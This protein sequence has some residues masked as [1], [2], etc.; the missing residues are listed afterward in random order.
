MTGSRKVEEMRTAANKI[1]KAP[2]ATMLQLPILCGADIELGNFILGLERAD[3]TAQIAAIA[4]LREIE[5]LPRLNET[6]RRGSQSIYGPS[7]NAL[8]HTRGLRSSFLFRNESS[9][10]DQGTGF[11][12]QDWGRKFLPANGGCAYIDLTTGVDLPEVISARI[13]AALAYDAQHRDRPRRRNKSSRKDTGA[14]AGAATMAKA[15]AAAAVPLPG[16][17]NSTGAR[18]IAFLFAFR[19]RK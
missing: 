7:K 17:D 3:G 6:F 15:A 10:E 4:L 2:E 5:G 16:W 14:G 13:A 9:E 11:N 8:D 19:H 18:C 12:P 1:T